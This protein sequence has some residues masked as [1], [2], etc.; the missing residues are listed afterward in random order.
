MPTEAGPDQPPADPN[1]QD[2]GTQ[3]ADP[4]PTGYSSLE[5]IGFDD[6]QSKFQSAVDKS[7]FAVQIPGYV[8][9]GMALE[10]FNL[11]LDSDDRANFDMYYTTAATGGKDA[12]PALHFWETNQ[13]N[14]PGDPAQKPIAI[15]EISASNSSWTYALL[16]YP[17]PDGRVMELYSAHTQATGG[18]Y[19]S[20]DIRVGYDP[21]P[22][23]RQNALTELQKVLASL[24]PATKD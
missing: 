4:D 12:R 24:T 21:T 2:A 5:A 20:A 18:L 13:A 8:P 7:P 16:T 3:V 17:Q 15:G 23:A 6:A 22:A 11:G 1:H 9:T 19:V 10:R 14:D